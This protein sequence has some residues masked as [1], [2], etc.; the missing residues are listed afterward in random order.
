MLHYYK[1]FPFTTGQIKPFD[2]CLLEESTEVCPL[3][4]LQVS[5]WN[6]RWQ[7]KWKRLFTTIHGQSSFVKYNATCVPRRNGSRNAT[8]ST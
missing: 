5:V 7:R 1:P 4:W 8:C 2:L 3:C 6:D